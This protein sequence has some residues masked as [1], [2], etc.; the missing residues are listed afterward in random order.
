MQRIS[1]SF[2]RAKCETVNGIIGVPGATAYTHLPLQVSLHMAYGYTSVIQYTSQ[3]GSHT[4]LSQPGTM[5]EAA[6]FLDGLITGLR[7]TSST[8]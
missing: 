7:M 8:K 6:L 3:D 4:T 2:L 5:R 1:E